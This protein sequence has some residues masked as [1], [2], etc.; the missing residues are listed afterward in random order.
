MKLDGTGKPGLLADKPIMA[1]TDG[2]G[3]FSVNDGVAFDPLVT[4]L[5]LI[6]N[7]VSGRR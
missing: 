2:A 6:E 5:G 4:V 1:P 7:P 3:P